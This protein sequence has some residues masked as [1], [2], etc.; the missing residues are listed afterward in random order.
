M[1]NAAVI[2][3]TVIT[4]LIISFLWTPRVSS[5]DTPMP[6]PPPPPTE[7]PTLPE[8]CWLPT[9]PDGSTNPDNGKP[10][11]GSGQPLDQPVQV[12]EMPDIENYQSCDNQPW[13]A[14]QRL[15]MADFEYTGQEEP[16]LAQTDNVNQVQNEYQPLSPYGTGRV[17]GKPS[18]EQ[19][20]A[21]PGVSA[22]DNSDDIS[23]GS[24]VSPS[25]TETQQGQIQG[26]AAAD[27]LRWDSQNQMIPMNQL[28]VA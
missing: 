23:M 19:I 1:K 24:G 18:A 7:I 26:S 22:W 27:Q 2:I 17:L 15:Q 9:N 3:A 8:D 28:D 25:L 11:C 13:Y 21:L 6:P 16:P 12:S 20:Q 5:Y 4:I 14:C 10:E